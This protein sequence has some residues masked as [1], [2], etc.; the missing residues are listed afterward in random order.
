[1]KK[2]LLLLLFTSAMFAQ[3]LKQVP[4]QILSLQ[5]K[6]MKFDKI[7]LFSINENY[8]HKNFEEEVGNATVL[9]LNQNALSSVVSEKPNYLQFS[10]P[11]NNKLIDIVLYKVQIETSDFTLDT[12]KQ[13]N[14]IVEKG[15][16]YRGIING[17]VNSI[18]SFNFYKGEANGIVSGNEFNNLNVGKLMASNNP[19]DYIVYSDL[20]LKK[21]FEFACDVKEDALKKHSVEE[22]GVEST[23]SIKCVS[24]YFE[25]DYQNYVRRGNSISATT[26]WFTSLFNNVQTLYANDGITVAIKSLFIW[27][28][29]D[30][31]IG[32][33]VSR[34]YLF[35]FEANRTIF[36]GDLAHLISLEAGNIGGVAYLNGI[37]GA[38]KH[39]YSN[40]YNSFSTVP[41]YSW[42]VEVIT[43]ELGHQMGSEH[44]HACAWNGNNT[45]IDGC[46]PTANSNYTEGSCPTGPVPYTERGS[47]M[48]YCH[49]LGN[50]GINF[51]NGFG[52]QPAARIL[53][54]VNAATC[55]STDCI[56]TCINTITSINVVN[57]NETSAQLTWID[58]DN[59]SGN[60]Q[61]A[62]VAYPYTSPTWI[63]VNNYSTSY[64]FNNLQSNAYYKFFVRP[65]CISPQVASSL[66][67]FQ[68]TETTNICS[69]VSFTDTGL[70]SR[71]YTDMENWVRTFT[72]PAGSVAKVTFT[73]I[74]LEANY[75][76]LYVHD[77]PNVNSP[78]LATLTG[79]L[80]N[81]VFEATNATGE[82]TFNFV[83]DQAVNEAGWN[84]TVSC[85]TLGVDA[86]NK[87][88]FS[89][90]P[91]PVTNELSLNSKEEISKIQIFTLDG[92]LIFD[93]N[94]N[95][96]ETKINT[97][98]FAM[99]TYIIKLTFKEGKNAAFKI[100]KQ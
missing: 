22:R 20:N 36:N 63:T 39:G 95:V 57:V 25:L 85:K 71:N 5:S 41:N 11:Y 8:N 18:V 32:G 80:T 79:S 64:T 14:I 1:M 81:Q 94:S 17:N 75:D 97:A 29:P 78:L 27:T 16:H 54:K 96:T 26:T 40:I 89:Y 28:T 56:N 62:A 72:P 84:A 82:L 35:S 60:W 90:Y 58:P 43:H 2:I 10:L 4:K 69:S 24:V 15:V 33:S 61:V 38:R 76:Y 59:A 23:N 55:L 30:P 73:S 65:A 68:A 50:V 52:P 92:K 87:N 67:K 44:T 70:L 21:P 34:D 100:V 91:N 66:S 77:G 51:A 83:S 6:N 86:F 98:S 37:C 31:Y 42:S 9:K 3:E 93:K 45:A 46:G 99:G 53:G 88:L 12:D 19:N 48:S 47:I 49:L 74:N 7:S 13:K